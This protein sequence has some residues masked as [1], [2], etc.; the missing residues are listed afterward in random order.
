[1]PENYQI[2]IFHKLA[3]IDSAQLSEILY[4]AESD[5]T[6]RCIEWLQVIEKSLSAQFQPYY[7]ALY[8][9]EELVGLCT[10][11]Y[12]PKMEFRYKSFHNN[13]KENVL[14]LS[15]LLCN[16]PLDNF[17]GFFFKKNDVAADFYRLFNKEMQE[18]LQPNGVYLGPFNDRE[19]ESTTGIFPKEFPMVSYFAI[20]YLD[21]NFSNFEE[22]LNYLKRHHRQDIK[23]KIKQFNSEGAVF[24]YCKN[25]EKIADTL[26]SFYIKTSEKHP[27]FMPINL[28]PAFFKEIS[29]HLGKRF[30]VLLIK[31][32]EKIIA[33]ALIIKKRDSYSLRFVGFDYDL[34]YGVAAYY[35]IFYETIRLAIRDKVKVL[36]LGATSMFD[37]KRLGC[38]VVR[39]QVF[40]GGYPLAIFK[41]MNESG[42]FEKHFVGDS[43]FLKHE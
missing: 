30:E 36:W 14:K 2:K 5:P 1:M 25:T 29:P 43:F 26:Y 16:F 40:I 39:P 15:T 32:D 27:M 17:N 13:G 19:I 18:N 11:A 42:M 9:N 24:E 33:F 7:F 3:D 41:R 8:L 21:I 37:K 34:S 20:A 23:T 4:S 22:Y 31:K 28:T 12:I 10:A 6:D 38:E 35:N